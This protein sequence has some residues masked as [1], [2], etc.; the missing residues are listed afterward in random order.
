MRILVAFAS[1]LAA[2]FCLCRVVSCLVLCE[3]ARYLP[4]G[5]SVIS[6]FVRPTTLSRGHASSMSLL[7]R[8]LSPFLPPLCLLSR[9]ALFIS[10]TLFFLQYFDPSSPS[11]SLLSLPIP[12]LV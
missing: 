12:H 11:C 7:C 10:F 3:E 4:G 9:L 8:N 6:G 1:P 5:G 2:A